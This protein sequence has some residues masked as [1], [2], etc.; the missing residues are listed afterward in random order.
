MLI[1]LIFK[2]SPIVITIPLYISIISTGIIGPILEEVLFRYI[3]LN[4]LKKFNTSKKSI[5]IATL[6]FAIV[7]GSIIKIIYAFILGLILNI[8]YHKYNNIK[9]NIL[10]HISA[11][12]IAIF[13]SSFNIY[14]LILSI[15]GLI[16]SSISI[17]KI[18]A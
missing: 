9:A 14:I 1:F 12:I 16:V 4:N 3:L 10:I 2:P 13:L 11:N 18:K 17:R 8:I 5:I 15:I 7:H 6:I